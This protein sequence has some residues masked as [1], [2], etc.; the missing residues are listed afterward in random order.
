MTAEV[1]FSVTLEELFESDEGGDIPDDFPWITLLI[2]EEVLAHHRLLLNEGDWR[3]SDVKDLWFRVD[4]E[5]PDM[6]QQRHVHVADKKHIKTPN[7]QASWNQDLT[8]HDRHKFNAAMGA[9]HSY[10]SVAKTALGLPD[11]AILEWRENRAAG[12]IALLESADADLQSEF[13]LWRGIARRSLFSELTG[14]RSGS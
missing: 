4:A 10:Q 1:E 12:Q 5:R 14:A 6:K 7:K 13:Y 2:P 11:S 8:R 3:P 9:R